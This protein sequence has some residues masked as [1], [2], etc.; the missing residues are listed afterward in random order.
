M[1]REMDLPSRK[2]MHQF[3]S[4]CP[5]NVQDIVTRKSAVSTQ[6]VGIT[7]LNKHRFYECVSYIILSYRY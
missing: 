4:L 3:Q 7:C 5:N 2:I 6:L 1:D